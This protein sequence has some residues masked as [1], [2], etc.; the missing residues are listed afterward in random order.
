MSDLNIPEFYVGGY[1]KSQHAC[2]LKEI[3]R[4]GLGL[5]PS[6]KRKVIGIW[7]AVTLFPRIA[8]GQ[9]EMYVYACCI[10]GCARAYTYMHAHSC[11]ELRFR[12]YSLS[13][14]NPYIGFPLFNPIMRQW[15]G[16]TLWRRL[17]RRTNFTFIQ[18]Y[19]NV[20]F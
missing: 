5:V 3:S 15:K 18:L 8:C 12:E 17:S 16:P 11:R 4:I 10:T 19:M 13:K 14:V 1:S 20:C 6:G 2:G 9:V 7:H